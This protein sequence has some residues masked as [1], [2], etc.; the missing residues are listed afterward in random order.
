MGGIFV[1]RR[2]SQSSGRST[3]G[4]NFAKVGGYS[5][6]SEDEILRLPGCRIDILSMFSFVKA[7]DVTGHHILLLTSTT[8]IILPSN[9]CKVHLA[10][11]KPSFQRH[12]SDNTMAPFSP[13][14]LSLPFAKDYYIE[15]S[16]IR[17][18]RTQ[19]SSERSLG[20]K[21]QY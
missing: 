8:W 6:S 21:E 2:L 16:R 5:A 20:G 10:E 12:I 1:S 19:Q 18:R 14:I 9:I 3:Y 13:P 11:I 15:S 17:C 7:Y 4:G